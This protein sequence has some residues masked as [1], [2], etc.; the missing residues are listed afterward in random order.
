VILH[1]TWCGAVFEIQ[2]IVTF[3]S[4]ACFVGQLVLEVWKFHLLLPHRVFFPFGGPSGSIPQTENPTW[5]V[6]Y[7]FDDTSHPL[8]CAE[9]EVSTEDKMQKIEETEALKRRMLAN[10]MGR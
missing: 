1:L 7:S 6:L 2:S 10:T 3:S 5:N 9:V 8:A 4:R